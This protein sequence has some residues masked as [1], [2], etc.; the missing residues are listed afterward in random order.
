LLNWYSASV[1]H[2]PRVRAAIDK[3]VAFLLDPANSRAYGVKELVRTTGFVGLAVAEVL[4]P[5]I[6]FQAGLAPATPLIDVTTGGGYFPVMI[7]LGGDDA[8]AVVRGGGAHIGRAGRLDIVRT[9]D[10]GKT[11][12]APRTA[13][14]SAEDDRNPAFG[15]LNDGTVLLAYAVL[16]G[17]DASGKRLLPE[18]A[19]WVFD[20]VYTMRS[21][22]QGAT[23]SRPKRS[24]AIHKF[25]AGQGAVSPYGKIVPLRD[26]TVVMPVYFE[27]NDARRNES[28]I[29]RSR[30]G[31]RTWGEPSL[32]GRH[33]NETSIAELPD[34]RLLAAM[35]S[36]EGGHIATAHS[37]DGGR[38][39]TEPSVVTRDS[40]HPADLI[41]TRAG[42]VVLTFGQRN[43]PFGAQA[44]LSRD[45]GATW[46]QSRKMILATDA[47]NGDCGYPSSVE[48]A[49]GRV[50]TMFYQVDD[51]ADAPRTARARAI[52]WEIPRGQT[53]PQ[54]K[55]E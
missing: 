30:D 12:S 9:K 51:S 13:V 7:G 23:W 33:F 53:L 31:G 39:W 36:E 42:E 29:F 35:R 20:G 44:L 55:G 50:L 25:Y 16:S 37:S 19:K 49:D 54:K 26:G 52:A 41:V 38:T 47:P 6:T 5:G 10:S 28:Y 17:Y 18:R 8:L 34:G 27:F 21:A 40:E 2:D 14:D 11:W 32:L 4:R 1:N 15:V 43:R 24:D 22:D 48:L 3:F 45:G 46:D